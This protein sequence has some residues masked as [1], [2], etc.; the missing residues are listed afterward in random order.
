MTGSG[1]QPAR[2]TVL[3]GI[4]AGVAAGVA[5]TAHAATITSSEAGQIWSGEYWAR[6]GDV[7]LWMYRKRIG[8]PKSGEPSRPVVFYVHGSSVTSRA[9]DLNVPGKGEYSVMN[10]FARYGF[11]C[12]TMDHENYG[13]S[14]R[15]SGNSDIASGVE[16]LKAA[17]EVLGRE[18]GQNKY[19]FI[20]ESSGAL[21]AGAY[22]MVAPERVGRLVFA[23][24]TYKG[25]GSPTLAKR[26]EQLEYYR[27][28][29][30][31]KRDRDM[32]RSI[33]TRDRPGT[34]DPA[35]VEALADVEMQFGDQIPTGTYL[36]MTANLP[37]V[38]PEKVL[39]PV[40]L[41]RGE[42]DGIATVADLEAFFNKLPSGDR[43]FVILPGTAHSVVL[44]TNR[45]LFWHAA[46][47]FLTMP[48]PIAT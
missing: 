15:T 14:G 39:A 5:G 33:A 38:H 22:A 25:E 21:R 8:A 41:V 4:G 30:M 13:K 46:R 10:E 28:H 6:K 24:F 44:A 45:Q 16:D 9:F 35:A 1:Y 34:S 7:P 17:V 27:S 26:A 43:Q 37:V 19:H 18:T 48:S 2:R 47:S 20:G 12:W 36:D 31:R 11:D 32:I 42:Y 29:N 40:L 3:Q 23:A